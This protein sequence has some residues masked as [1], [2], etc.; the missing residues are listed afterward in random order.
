M[1]RT[2][3]LCKSHQQCHSW[4]L[5]KR[6]LSIVEL[7]RDYKS[8]PAPVT[9]TSLSNKPLKISRLL[10]S[11]TLALHASTAAVHDLP[12][13]TGAPAVSVSCPASQACMQCCCARLGTTMKPASRCQVIELHARQAHM[14]HRAYYG[15]TILA[16]QLSTQLVQ[17][18]AA[19]SKQ[20]ISC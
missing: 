2:C 3:C 20:V 17:L 11:P 1:N 9:V 19:A 5:H 16:T 4:L 8:F 7:R 14:T 10:R 18:A 13:R 6:L 12:T 15:G